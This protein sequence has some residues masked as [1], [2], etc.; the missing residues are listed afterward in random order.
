MSVCWAPGNLLEGHGEGSCS[1]RRRRIKCHWVLSMGSAARGLCGW[2]VLMGAGGAKSLS[3]LERQSDTL[4]QKETKSSVPP[5]IHP[6]CYFQA[7]VIW[8][9]LSVQGGNLPGH[10]PPRAAGGSDK[11]RGGCAWVLQ[12]P[13]CGR[14]CV[15]T[16]PFALSLGI[17]DGCAAASQATICE[18]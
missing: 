4:P 6:P 14:N 13:K 15:L 16:Q 18:P 7:G 3:S 17:M 1:D 2:I 11:V 10:L 9:A 12:H 5:S 8:A